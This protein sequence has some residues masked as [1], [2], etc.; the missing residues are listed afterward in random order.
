MASAQIKAVGSVSGNQPRTSSQ[1]EEALQTFLQ[2]TPVS[3]GPVTGGVIAW[4]G[5]TI[6][7]GIAGISVT[8]ARNRATIGTPTFAGDAVPNQA[9]PALS[10][11]R[12][13]PLDDGNQ[14]IEVAAPDTVFKGQVGPAQL[15]VNAVIGHNYGLTIDTDNH[16]FVD[17]TID[18]QPTSVVNCVGKDTNDVRGIL[19][20]FIPE[21]AQVIA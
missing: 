14:I 21:V 6:G 18:N 4:D 9:A 2:G 11:Y 10:I 7:N 5:V 17:L 15:V 12:G 8:T 20:T 1:P 16:W 19:F 3:L 13:S